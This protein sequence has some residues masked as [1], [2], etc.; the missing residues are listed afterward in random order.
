[1]SFTKKAKDYLLKVISGKEF[2]PQGLVEI[3]RY[4]RFYGPINFDLKKEDDAIVGISNN[5]QFGSIITSGKNPEELDKNIKDAI[6]ASFEIP[7]SYAKEAAIK[8]INTNEHKG[9]ALA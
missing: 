6:L 7:S 1:M 3:N 4:F 2:V 5:F 8:N 9:Y